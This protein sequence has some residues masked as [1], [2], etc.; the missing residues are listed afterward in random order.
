MIDWSYKCYGR[1]NHHEGNILLT[2][3]CSELIN[4]FYSNVSEDKIG[5]NIKLSEIEC[6]Y[7]VEDELKTI[8]LKGDIMNHFC[9]N[10]YIPYEF[11]ETIKD[12][13]KKRDYEQSWMGYLNH[14]ITSRYQLTDEEK[15]LLD[16]KSKMRLKHIIIR[17]P[18][19][20]FIIKFYNHDT[21]TNTI[22]YNVLLFI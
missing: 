19:I 9:E 1:G 3:Y 15:S 6:E 20:S 11:N 18:E 16:F 7:F 12:C 10:F 2:D 21:L 5:M 4:D 22:K 14:F 13:I 17:Y 8:K